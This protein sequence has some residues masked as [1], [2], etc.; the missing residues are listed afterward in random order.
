MVTWPIF[1]RGMVAGCLQ[2]LRS[3]W[4][5]PCGC[6]D[7]FWL[8]RWH[9]LSIGATVWVNFK[10]Q[11]TVDWVHFEVLIWKT[12]Q[13]LGTQFSTIA[14]ANWWC[15]FGRPRVFVLYL[16]CLGLFLWFCCGCVHIFSIPVFCSLSIL[17]NPL[18]HV[19][20]SRPGHPNMARKLIGTRLHRSIQMLGREM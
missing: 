9:E 14:Y 4:G 20:H 13:L 8:L 6:S 7:S 10:M 11:R 17:R 18:L 3:C 19:S 2:P 15:N 5:K 12:I 16:G 1:C